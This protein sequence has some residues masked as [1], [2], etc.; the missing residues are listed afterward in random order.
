[1]DWEYELNATPT[2]TQPEQPNCQCRSFTL[3]HYSICLVQCRTRKGDT[4]AIGGRRESTT[5]QGRRRLTRDDDDT[6]SNIVCAVGVGK[7]Q[8]A[9]AM[10]ASSYSRPPIQTRVHAASWHHP[11]L[12]FLRV[13][14]R[15]PACPSHHRGPPSLPFS[16]Q[17]EDLLPRPKTLNVSPSLPNSSPNYTLTPTHI[18][19][20]YHT[21]WRSRTY[22]VAP[23]LF[24][25]P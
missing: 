9:Q 4:L 23:Q 15:H 8:G 21:T 7:T 3:M 10:Q 22:P 1:M 12:R 20:R 5:R 24:S 16:A 18:A 19:G 11:F 13:F 6:G 2:H 14:P 25:M 17:G